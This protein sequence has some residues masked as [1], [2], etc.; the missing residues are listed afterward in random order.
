MWIDYA[1]ALAASVVQAAIV[2]ATWEAGKAINRAIERRA[3]RRA[4]Q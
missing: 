2:V 4:Q 3:K 1:T